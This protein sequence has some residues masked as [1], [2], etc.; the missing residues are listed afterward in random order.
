[1]KITTMKITSIG[2][3]RKQFVC[4]LSEII[5]H[6]MDIDRLAQDIRSSS[7]AGCGGLV[8]L[9]EETESIQQQ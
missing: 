8:G 1:M 3:A 6:G 4:R 9:E 5:R 2:E 7:F